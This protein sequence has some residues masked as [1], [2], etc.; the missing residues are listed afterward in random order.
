MQYTKAKVKS[1]KKKAVFGNLLKTKQLQTEG[2]VRTMSRPN[3]AKP[4][5]IFGKVKT[6][7]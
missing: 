4:K 3:V 1:A 7:R 5:G 2:G 6:K